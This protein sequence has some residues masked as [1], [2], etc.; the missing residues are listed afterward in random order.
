MKKSKANRVTEPLAIYGKKKSP[1]SKGRLVKIS[2][3][4][5]K[6]Q[7]KI[8]DAEKQ[9]SENKTYTNDE[10]KELVKKVLTK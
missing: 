3:L 4:P 6:L 9:L 8:R 1:S 2:E 5:D 10:V 7:K